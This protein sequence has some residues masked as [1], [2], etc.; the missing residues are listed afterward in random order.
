M[1]WFSNAKIRTKIVLGFLV[2][3]LIAGAIGLVGIININT[4]DNLDTELYQKIAA[5]LGDMVTITSA[6]Q[7][8]RGNVKDILLSTTETEIV[9]YETKISER[10]AEFNTALDSFSKTLLTDEGKAAYNNLK[11]NA[12][13]YAGIVAD[14]ISD[15]RRGKTEEA[16]ALNYGKG[17]DIRTLIE[18][19]YEQLAKQKVELGKSDIGW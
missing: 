5:P 4:I 8:I 17:N 15:V 6:F 18:A 7:R 14:I 13:A 11:S 9:D 2:V 3:A 1:K 19:D 10:W 12:G 16:I